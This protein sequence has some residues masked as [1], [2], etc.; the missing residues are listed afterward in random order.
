MW[1]PGHIE[2]GHVCDNCGEY[3]G[4]MK[5]AKEWID[6][7]RWRFA[8]DKYNQEIKTTLLQNEYSDELL[9]WN[10]FEKLTN[11]SELCK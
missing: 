11:F 9:T 3:L 6:T 1:A 4:E 5:T 2:Q 10:Q 7:P 8:D